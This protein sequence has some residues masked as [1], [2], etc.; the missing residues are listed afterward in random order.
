M[1]IIILLGFL[2]SGKTTCLNHLL[3][4]NISNTACI[5]NEFGDISIDSRWLLSDHNVYDVKQGS[6]FCQ[7]KMEEFTNTM[8]QLIKK[9]IDV[10][11]VETTGFANPSTLTSLIQ[12]IFLDTSIHYK[13]TVVTLV[14]ARHFLKLSAVL[15]ILKQQVE[16]ADG[17]IINKS[18]LVSQE[19]LD[20]TQKAITTINPEALTTITTHGR[21]SFDWLMSLP[22]LSTT[23]ASYQIKNITY[24][25]NTCQLESAIDADAINRLSS[26]FQLIAIRIKGFVE[27]T[28]GNFLLQIV[29]ED[30]QWHP[31]DYADN[32]LIIHTLSN[33]CSIDDVMTIFI[34][35]G[36]PI[37]KIET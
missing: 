1:N 10:V 35:N 25:T 19:T 34:S 15:P 24:T 23:Q 3:K 5:I 28:K 12:N 31:S 26:H 6:I 32:M 16:H 9:D 11:F 33:Q 13:I 8:K 36:I 14:D 22:T 2:G 30:V 27:T 20:K 7:C 18:D 21:V 37:K 4:L 17:L 29:Q